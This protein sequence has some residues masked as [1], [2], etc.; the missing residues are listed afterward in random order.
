MDCSGRGPGEDRGLV[1]G[2]HPDGPG[3]GQEGHEALG[4]GHRPGTRASPAVGGG[5]GL[6]QVHVDDV[7]AHV[8]G[9]HH[10]EDGVEIGAVVVQEPADLVHGGGDGGDVLLEQSQG[11]RDWSA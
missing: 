11:V 10:A 7:E 8:A 9:S 5:E 3:S 4:H 1:V 6:V 2:G